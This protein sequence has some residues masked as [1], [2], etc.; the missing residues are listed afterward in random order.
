[1]KG[2]GF[3]VVAPSEVHMEEF[4]SLEEA[5]DHASWVATKGGK[6]VIYMPVATIRPHMQTRAHLSPASIL[7]QVQHLTSGK[8]ARVQ[9]ALGSTSEEAVVEVDPPQVPD[10]YDV[11]AAREVESLAPT[12]PNDRDITHG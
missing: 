6:A 8:A 12:D 3:I 7:Q 11:D 1:M 9:H 4:A 5:N 10:K 2:D